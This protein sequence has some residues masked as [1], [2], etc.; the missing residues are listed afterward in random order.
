MTELKENP[1]P[2]PGSDGEHA[3]Q[4]ELGN[5]KRALGFY[6]NQMLD[7]LNP[8]MQEFVEK[9]SMMFVA[10]S[11]AHGECDCT[12]RAGDAGF[13]RVI[14]SKHIIWPEYRG[15]GVTASAGNV[16]ENPH[17]GVLFI[18]FVKDTVGLHI[19]GK[20]QL[21]IDGAFSEL[22]EAVQALIS[23]EN[24]TTGGKKPVFWFLLEV[25]EAYM[26]CAKHIPRFMPVDKHLDWG[27]DDTLKK[28]G[29]Y[30]KAKAA[31]RRS[32]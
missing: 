18:D 7:Y 29:D 31:K 27:T 23:V 6:N 11:D 4:V 24:A 26:H 14:D 21:Q 28:G 25:E 3:L 17:M 32:I 20:V 9:Q 5:E 10:S 15:N 8:E 1:I 19:N 22:P 12:F 13:V 30:F 2:L 16:K